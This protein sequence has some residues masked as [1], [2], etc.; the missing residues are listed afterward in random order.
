MPPDYLRMKRKKKRGSS[1][2]SDLLLR[3]VGELLFHPLQTFP[4]IDLLGFM[5]G[6]PE[7]DRPAVLGNLLEPGR[8]AVGE[9]EPTPNRVKSSLLGLPR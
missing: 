1:R 7:R 5:D 8:P 6:L 4:V 9:H 3:L 2:S